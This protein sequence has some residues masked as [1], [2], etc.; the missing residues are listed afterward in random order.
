MDKNK[1]NV[2]VSS[3]NNNL[4]KKPTQE[5]SK[6]IIFDYGSHHFESVAIVLILFTILIFGLIYFLASP[7]FVK[8]KIGQN[9]I[10]G[11]KSYSEY[12]NILNSYQTSYKIPVQ[13]SGG[14]IKYYSMSDVGLSIDQKKTIDQIQ[15]NRD[16]LANRFQLWKSHNILLSTAIDTKKYQTFSDHKLNQV[17]QAPKNA[18][19]TIDKGQLVL[20]DSSVGK[21]FGISNGLEQIINNTKE[22]KST[23]IVLSIVT[24]N[25]P[26]TTQQLASQEPKINSIL[27][28]DISLKVGDSHIKVSRV[29][30]ASWMSLSIDGKNGKITTS[31]SKDNISAYVNQLASKYSRSVKN[32][33]VITNSDGNTTVVQAGHD[34][35]SVTGQTDATNT[36]NS[37]LTQNKPASVSLGVITK[38]FSTTTALDENKWIEVD[39]T[40][41][42]MYIYQNNTL[43]KTFLVS[44]GKSSTPTPVGTFHIFSKIPLQTMSG[45]GYVQPDVPW[46][47]Y[48]LAGGYSI[49]GNY[50]REPSWFGNINSS[51]G[52]VGLQVSD[53][54]WVYNWAPIGT[55]I[56]THT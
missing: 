37:S 44:A 16:S 13:Y 26:I 15:M 6:N 43:I 30:I 10:K 27:D 54:E 28:Q 9:T 22:L 18:N 21:E 51:H 53:A 39:L 17:I 25:P 49:H 14:I 2:G 33:I 4:A 20:T 31:I 46:I 38:P 12:S 56:V 48:F 42:K 23:P 24:L 29:D 11:N 55:T 50:W 1:K 41:K 34:G 3:V 5:K 7:Y 45:V 35:S 40:I 8:I 19:L 32:Q 47:N 52:C 36:I